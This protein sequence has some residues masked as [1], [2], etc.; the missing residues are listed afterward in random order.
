MV[1]AG[2]PLVLIM[3]GAPGAGKGTYCKFLIERFK[4]PQIS[5]GDM[6]R[7]AVK[8]GTPLGKEAK[9]YMDKGA[10]V[11]D[12][13]TIGLVKERVT[14]ADCQ[15]GFILDGFPRTVPQAEALDSLL[16]SLKLDLHVVINLIVDKDMLFKRL[17]GRRMCRGCSK[18]N[19]NVYTLPPKKEGVCDYCGGQLYQRDDDKEEV[20]TKRLQVYESQTAPLVAYYQAKGKLIPMPSNG[21][22]E[23][24][25]AKI[26]SAIES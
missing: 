16:S 22:V 23:E 1:T 9:K 4:T 11:P 20:I 25:T 7:A 8:Q 3:L 19:F 12:E 18:G 2:K 15:P 21:K 17:T 26:I 10:L 5:T 14:Q 24:M 13:V 6:F